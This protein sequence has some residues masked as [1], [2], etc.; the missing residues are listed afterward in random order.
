MNT[1]LPLD[2]SS[3]ESDVFYLQLSSKEVSP[4][5]KK[6][7]AVL[8]A[9]QLS[10]AIAKETFTISSVVAP[11]ELQI[12][13]I[14]LD[15]EGPTILYGFGN[16]HPIVLPS[17]KDLNLPPDPFKVWATMAAIQPDK[18][19]SPQSPETSNQSPI[20]T[21]P[22]NLDTL[23]GW[24]TPHTTT[25]ENTFFSEDEPRRVYWVISSGE[26]F[27]TYEP[28]QVPSTSITSSTPLPPRRQ[29]SELSMGMSF[30]KKRGMLQHTSEAGGQPPPTRKPS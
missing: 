8:N 9:M 26:N 12:V 3:T 1:L 6:T 27:D 15:A 2:T 13:T 28:R 11:P 18:E 23:E 4:T 14:E 24:E 30:P 22:M 25:D 10:R 5:Q 29:K 17:L 21:P 19:Y 7:P 20:S 16:Q